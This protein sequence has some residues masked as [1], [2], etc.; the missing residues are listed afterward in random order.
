M[1]KYRAQ[2]PSKKQRL[3]LWKMAKQMYAKDQ[4]ENQES[5]KTENAEQKE[6]R[7]FVPPALDKS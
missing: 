7:K 4:N 2:R 6:K 3:E 1:R 5:E